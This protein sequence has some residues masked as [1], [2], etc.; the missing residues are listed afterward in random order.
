[1]G[2][3]FEDWPAF[4]LPY[5]GGAIPFACVFRLNVKGPQSSLVGVF[6]GSFSFSERRLMEH[7]QE[8][9]SPSA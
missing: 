3:V 4:A 9:A 8:F 7:V 6:V 1:M 2:H 5:L